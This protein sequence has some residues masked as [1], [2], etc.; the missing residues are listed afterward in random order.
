MPKRPES[1][2][3]ITGPY[4]ELARLVRELLQWDDPERRLSGRTAQ[5]LIG[6]T[7]SHTTIIAMAEGDRPRMDTVID[8]GHGMKLDMAGVNRL[9]RAA[10]YP[11]IMDEPDDIYA[12]ARDIGLSEEDARNL[13]ARIEEIRREKARRRG[14]E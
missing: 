1:D 6:N 10:G 14:G 9:L 12:A 2:K 8:F 4:K 13:L 11:Q 3:P 7:I 5:R